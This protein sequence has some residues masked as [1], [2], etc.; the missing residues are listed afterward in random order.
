MSVH[1]PAA[2]LPD[3]PLP[4]IRPLPSI[5]GVGC[6]GGHATTLIG[7]QFGDLPDIATVLHIKA[8]KKAMDEQIYALIQ[9]ELPDSL[10][11]DV[12]A[13]RAAELAAYVIEIVNTINTII[14]GIV[15]EAEAA[16]A[17]VHEKIAEME[18]ALAVIESV[19]SYARTALQQL[20][21]GRYNEYVAELNGQAARLQSTIACVAAIG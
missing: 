20:M 14:G 18:S 10:R 11:P 16:I 12:Y 5:P 7:E 15:A 19:P 1:I 2:K 8:L 6:A 17:A 3:L 13:A 9:G 4:T 21:F